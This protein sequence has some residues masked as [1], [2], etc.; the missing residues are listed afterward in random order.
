MEAPLLLTMTRTTLKS[1]SSGRAVL[2]GRAKKL[3]VP[4]LYPFLK[5]EHLSQC[6]YF[7]DLLGIIHLAGSVRHR[8]R[9]AQDVLTHLVTTYGHMAREL[10]EAKSNRRLED[11]ELLEFID[12]MKRDVMKASLVEY[13][14]QQSASKTTIAS[15]GPIPSPDVRVMGGIVPRV[16]FLIDNH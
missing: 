2:S 6:D 8:R 16:T 9:A 13:L 12:C 10:I 7:Q 1:W 14:V 11:L 4:K 15:A 3:K 5:S